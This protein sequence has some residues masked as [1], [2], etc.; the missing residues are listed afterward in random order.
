[1][2]L[3]PAA[4]TRLLGV[5]PKYAARRGDPRRLWK[6]VHQFGIWNFALPDADCTGFDIYALFEDELRR[7]GD[8]LILLHPFTRLRP[9]PIPSS[10]SRV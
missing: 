3:D 7:A 1:L 9:W 8:L 5:E 2:D 6:D 10:T 4:I